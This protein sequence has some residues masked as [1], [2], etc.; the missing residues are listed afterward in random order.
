MSQYL[1]ASIGHTTAMCEHITWWAP[2]SKGYRVC[3]DKAGLYSEDQA[4]RICYTGECIAVPKEVAQGLSRGT[5]Y[6]RRQDG[7]LNKLYDGESH[8]VVPNSKDAW[9][10]LMLARL[11]CAQ[12]TTKATPISTAKARAIYLPA[13]MQLTPV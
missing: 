12:H 2:D 13:S 3:I 6:Y 7:T 8:T 4:K 9:M 10:H 5:P 1:I 11:P